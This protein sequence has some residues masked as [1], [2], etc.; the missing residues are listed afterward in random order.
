M[1]YEIKSYAVAPGQMPNCLSL[2]QDEGYRYF[3]PFEKN[4]LGYFVTEVGDLNR[5]VQF[6]KFE[7][8]A[9]RAAMLAS[10]RGDPGFA[11]FGAKLTPSLQDQKCL[12]MRP[13]PFAKCV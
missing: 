5:L 2:Y 6:W 7:D 3:K 11:A 10:L 9:E 8:Y 1:L 13:A 4:L 12:L